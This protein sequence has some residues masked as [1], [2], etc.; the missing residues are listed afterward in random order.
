MSLFVFKA[1]DRRCGDQVLFSFTFIVQP[2]TIHTVSLCLR[3]LI[4][5]MELLQESVRLN[6]LMPW[7]VPELESG[8]GYVGRV[9]W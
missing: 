6:S 1:Q 2:W 4:H 7:K 3:S 5:K 9:D 8:K